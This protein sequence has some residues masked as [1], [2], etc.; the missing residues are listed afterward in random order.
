MA[1][2]LKISELEA[3]GRGSGSTPA[4][5][6]QAEPDESEP[7]GEFHNFIADIEDLITSMTSLTGEDLTRAKAK[8]SARVA[9]A[10]ESIDEM[11]SEVVQRARKTARVTNR[12]V[13][14]NPWQAVGIGA[15]LGLLIGVLL[16]RRN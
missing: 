13:E 5:P 16:G 3:N 6:A 2:N 7:R 10:R 1:S 4:A 15:A 9:A 8:L 12:Y 14:D 11:S